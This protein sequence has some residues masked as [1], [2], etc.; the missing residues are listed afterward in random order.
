MTDIAQTLALMEQEHDKPLDERNWRE[1]SYADGV[2]AHPPQ[3]SIT[4]VGK[5]A[6]DN[7]YTAPAG[8]DGE[9]ALWTAHFFDNAVW[10]TIGFERKP[11]NYYSAEHALKDAAAA[12]TEVLADGL[13]AD[14][15]ADGDQGTKIPADGWGIIRGE[16]QL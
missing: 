12:R 1:R 9:T 14:T 3:G 5:D 13:H 15:Q 11:I 2:F 10:R 8:R 4:F 7:C 16:G 6:A